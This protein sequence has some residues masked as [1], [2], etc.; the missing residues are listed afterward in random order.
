MKINYTILNPIFKPSK[1]ANIQ[2]EK[3]GE[4]I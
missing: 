2:W 4:T 1:R 3:D